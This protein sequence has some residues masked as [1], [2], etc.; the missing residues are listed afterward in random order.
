MAGMEMILRLRW[1]MKIKVFGSRQQ[2]AFGEKARKIEG[3]ESLEGDFYTRFKP[4]NK[5][6][7]AVTWLDI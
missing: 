3:L 2:V 4:E 6:F 1:G 5:G 7:G